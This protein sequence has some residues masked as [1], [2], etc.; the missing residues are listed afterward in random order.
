MEID[1]RC[2]SWGHF[3]GGIDSSVIVALAKRHTP[4]LNTFSI[5]F[6][7]EGVF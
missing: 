5:G 4:N 2:T 6:Q 7:D 1:C 3:Y